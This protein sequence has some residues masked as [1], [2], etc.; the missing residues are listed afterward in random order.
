MTNRS[1]LYQTKLIELGA[2]ELTEA[3]NQEEIYSI[4][5]PQAYIDVAWQL[6]R[7]RNRNSSPPVLSLNPLVVAAWNST[8]HTVPKSWSRGGAWLYT[9]QQPT[10][11]ALENLGFLVREWLREEFTR[12]L[13]SDVEDYLDRVKDV[14]WNFQPVPLNFNHDLPPD[15]ILYQAIPNY[16][17]RLFEDN[18]QIRF[19]TDLP[20]L[21]FYR[22][23]TCES[24]AELISFPP[25]PTGDSNSRFPKYISF[26][27]KI[28]LRTL[29]GRTAPLIYCGLGVRRWL[30]YP[31]WLEGNESPNRVNSSGVT[32]YVS[33]RFRWLDGEEQEQSII[34]IKLYRGGETPHLHRAL[35]QLIRDTNYLPS[36]LD[37][38]SRSL[39]EIWDGNTEGIIAAIAYH[40]RLGQHPCKP[41]VSIKDIG[42]LNAHITQHLP[43]RRAGEIVPIPINKTQRTSGQNREESNVV[44]HRPSVVSRSLFMSRFPLE[45]ILILYIYPS[46]KDNLIQEI[47]TVLQLNRELEVYETETP[48]GIMRTVV[49]ASQLGDL[50]QIRIQTLGGEE[51]I[52]PLTLADVNKIPDARAIEAAKE[53]VEFFKR[54][55]PKPVGRSGAILEI[56]EQDYYPENT[57]PYIASK[58]ALMQKGYVNQRIHPLNE[59]SEEE[60]EAD[61]AR[62][63]NAVA[64][65]FSQAGVL[66]E[67][68]FIREED[69]ISEQMW[70]TCCLVIRRTSTTTWSGLPSLV[71]V[72]VRVNPFLGEVE[73]TTPYLKQQNQGN[74]GWVS[75]WEI[76]NRLLIE[77]WDAQLYEDSGEED[78]NAEETEEQQRDQRLLNQFLASCLTDCLS[79][80]INN[81]TKPD[82]LLMLDGQNARYTFKWLQ[83][84]NLKCGEFPDELRRHIQL[85][86]RQKRLHLVRSLT[87]GNTLETPPW[88]PIGK[89]PGSRHY[90]IYVWRSVCDDP[91]QEIYL[92]LR[93]L[94]DTEQQVLKVNQSRLD[95]GKRPAGN[96]PLLE[97]DIVHSSFDALTLI[98]FLERL[99]NRWAYF[100]GTTSLPFPF[101]YAKHARNYA[102]SL[103]DEDPA[104]PN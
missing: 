8:F 12:S 26:V 42:T 100:S 63:R 50:F 37:I 72:V 46:T 32:V 70:L 21:N 15:D 82:V 97:Y 35:S 80:P 59:K 92:G 62:V 68:F 38:A 25:K 79:T 76:Y 31:L 60:P 39:P 102:I 13:G 78:L 22:V 98:R 53:R 66:P 74:R 94:L 56:F 84:S 69:S 1:N 40:S 18:R 86:D 55:I 48:L 33:N 81:A 36:A 27:L 96:P 75:S 95:S 52:S 10:P 51:L 87:K 77:N 99:R 16:L 7:R 20:P 17:A 71:A 88:N 104:S 93:E 44:M 43:L 47:R 19:T 6:A 45:T 3:I 64:D 67:Q 65:L 14:E 30:T 29:Q 57:D 11:E 23:A 49:Y 54:V 85:K 24:G 4:T 90:G 83:N 91:E 41:G 103:R 5:P 89:N 2:W 61:E 34:P 9:T 101:P 73:F 58:I 28:R